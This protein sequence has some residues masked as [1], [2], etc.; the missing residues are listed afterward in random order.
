MGSSRTV[1]LVVQELKQR[2]L[3]NNNQ[4]DPRMNSENTE[5]S[6]E[7]TASVNMVQKWWKDFVENTVAT[8]KGVDGQKLFRL[9]RFAVALV[10]V[11]AA[12]VILLW[13]VFN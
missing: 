6:P 7:D 2:K 11:I 10:L 3:S 9:F 8:L 1:S 5:D 4:M 12:F 13:P